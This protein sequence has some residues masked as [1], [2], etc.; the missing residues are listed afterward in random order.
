[1]PFTINSYAELFF[2]NLNYIVIVD[3]G[4]F[5]ISNRGIIKSFINKYSFTSLKRLIITSPLL[6]NE[7][8]EAGKHLYTMFTGF[9]PLDAK[10]FRA[11][12]QKT[13][14]YYYLLYSNIEKQYELLLALLNKYKQSTERQ[15]IIVVENIDTAILIKSRLLSILPNGETIIFNESGAVLFLKILIFF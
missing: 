8:I 10:I 4:S 15:F 7:F 2:S 14:S 12:K 9:E 11:R 13:V 6:D 1:M 3:N 5:L